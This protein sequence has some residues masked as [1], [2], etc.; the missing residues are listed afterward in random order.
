MTVTPASPGKA[1]RAALAPPVLSGVINGSLSISV[2]AQISDRL[3]A[4]RVITLAW[5]KGHRTFPVARPRRRG[6]ARCNCVDV[7]SLDQRVPATQ[8]KHS[9]LW[10]TYVRIDQ[11]ADGSRRH[12]P[13]LRTR[14]GKVSTARGTWHP[15]SSRAR[16]VCSGPTRPPCGTGGHRRTP[17]RSTSSASHRSR[18]CRRRLSSGHTSA[19]RTGIWPARSAS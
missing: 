9:S 17:G 14:G 10:A 18:P 2:C 5:R 8:G 12:V 16:C 3:A 1:A 13:V 19:A 15:S 7:P 11:A 6:D 4:G